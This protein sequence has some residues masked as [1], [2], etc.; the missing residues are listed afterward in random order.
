MRIMIADDWVN[1]KRALRVM[2]EQQPG[3]EVTNEAADAGELIAMLLEECPD[4]LL[5]GWEL[6][7]LGIDISLDNL[8]D[9]CPGLA[10]IVL[11]GRADARHA[12]LTAGADNFVS[13]AASPEHLLVAIAAVQADGTS[14]DARPARKG[15][16]SGKMI[17]QEELP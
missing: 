7:G 4:L 2:L 17:L 9:H 12:A 13:K 6:P 15:H 10:I 8:R 1:V 3:F 5:L 14:E 11:S 16:T